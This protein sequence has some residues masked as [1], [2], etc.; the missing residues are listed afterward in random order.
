VPESCL[1]QVRDDRRR[2][3]AELARPIGAGEPDRLALALKSH[4]R[5]GNLALFAGRRRRLRQAP[6]RLSSA[7]IR[8]G[9]FPPTFPPTRWARGRSPPPPPLLCPWMPRF[10]GNRGILNC[11]ARCWRLTFLAHVQIPQSPRRRHHHPGFLAYRR[12]RAF[13]IVR[14][15]NGRRSR[16]PHFKAAWLGFGGKAGLTCFPRMRSSARCS[17]LSSFGSGGT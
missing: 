16:N 6:L 7:L 11:S 5:L 3:A 13:T 2:C 8:Q 1:H 17:A 9:D 15:L 10:V 12:A 4:R 14:L